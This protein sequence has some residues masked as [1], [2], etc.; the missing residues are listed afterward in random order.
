MSPCFV[1]EEGGQTPPERDEFGEEVKMGAN[2]EFEKRKTER[3]FRFK[4]LHN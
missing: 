3:F 2:M 1:L 4:I